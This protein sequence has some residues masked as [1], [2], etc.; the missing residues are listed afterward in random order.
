MESGHNRRVGDRARAAFAPADR[1][2]T[3]RTPR[4]ALDAEVALRRSGRNN[5][6]VQVFDLSPEGCRIEFVDRP[7]IDEMLWVKFEGLEAVPATVCWLR[8]PL[9][10]LEFG[11]PIHPAVF[12]VLL[13]RLRRGV[14]RL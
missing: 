9:A 4:V 1:P 10:G 11:R 2:Q 7:D 8:G 14:H 13:G 6:R 5:Y 3:R 12:E